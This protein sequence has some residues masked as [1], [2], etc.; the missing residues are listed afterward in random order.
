MEEHLI[1]NNVQTRRPVAAW[2]PTVM[3]APLPQ[4]SPLPNGSDVPFQNVK[5]VTVVKDSASTLAGTSLSPL[6]LLSQCSSIPPQAAARK[7]RQGELSWSGISTTLPDWTGQEQSS[8]RPGFR[9]WR[10]HAPCESEGDEVNGWG[11]RRQ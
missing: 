1:E 5:S 3:N 10:E 7:P 6:H 9:S 11:V 4:R 2:P 8:E